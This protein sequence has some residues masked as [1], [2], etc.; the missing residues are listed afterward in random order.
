MYASLYLFLVLN[1]HLILECF[2]IESPLMVLIKAKPLGILKT[3][4]T[5]VL[6]QRVFVSKMIFLIQGALRVKQIHGNC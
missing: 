5:M 1:S 6:K 3:T 4:E 2:N